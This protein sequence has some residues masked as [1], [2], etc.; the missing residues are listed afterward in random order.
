M[1]DAAIRKLLESVKKAPATTTIRYE[2][3]VDEG[4]LWTHDKSVIV[5]L[6]DSISVTS[7]ESLK[8]SDAILERCAG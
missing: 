2:V 7:F 6:A 4:K 3:E 8:L 5:F 1:K